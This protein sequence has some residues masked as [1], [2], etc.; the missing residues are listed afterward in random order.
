MKRQ[1]ENVAPIACKHKSSVMWS[2]TVGLSTRLVWDQKNR[3]WSWSWSWWS[4][5]VLWN[6]VLS[7]SLS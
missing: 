5:V 7:R 2:E 3:S 1:I 6:T 4:G